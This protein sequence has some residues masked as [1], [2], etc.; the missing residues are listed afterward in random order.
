MTLPGTQHPCIVQ[1]LCFIQA[2]AQLLVLP[3]THTTSC[4]LCVPLSTKMLPLNVSLDT[5]LSEKT[6][7]FTLL[8]PGFSIL[9]S[10]HHM[11]LQLILCSFIS[12]FIPKKAQ[13]RLQSIFFFSKP[14]FYGLLK[15]SSW[16]LLLFFQFIFFT[17]MHCSSAWKQRNSKTRKGK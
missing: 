4:L 6:S 5:N 2:T 15:H 14:Y 7:P 8:L 10:R 16:C 11:K 9:R 1:R 17:Q 12:F 3:V 13:L